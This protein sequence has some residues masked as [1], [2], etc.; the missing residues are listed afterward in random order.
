MVLIEYKDILINASVKH[1]YNFDTIKDEIFKK[2]VSNQNSTDK[3][4][5]QLI[6]SIASI[7]GGDYR[8][9]DSNMDSNSIIY[10]VLV[11]TD[12]SFDIHG[13]NYI[14]N[15]GFRRLLKEKGID[16][17]NVRNVVILNLNELLKFQ[18]FF[19]NG[20][21]DMIN[22]LDEYVEMNLNPRNLEEAI[23]AFEEFMRFKTRKEKNFT[24]EMLLKEVKGMLRD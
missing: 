7:R 21:L 16:D 24:P 17:S 14:L 9:V 13:V 2:L 15:K 4:I 20:N 23:A 12:E 19:R 1:S 11:I 3:G 10:P 5:S 18:D 22:C 6:N 8:Q